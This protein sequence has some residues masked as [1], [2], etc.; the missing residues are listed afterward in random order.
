MYAI[1]LLGDNANAA[2]RVNHLSSCKQ[3]L[4]G[5]GGDCGGLAKIG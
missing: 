4:D 2:V 3:F 5:V 1:D